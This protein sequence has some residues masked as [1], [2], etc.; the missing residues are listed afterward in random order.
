VLVRCADCQAIWIRDTLDLLPD[1]CAACRAD[2]P[3]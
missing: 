2:P 3:D 1:N